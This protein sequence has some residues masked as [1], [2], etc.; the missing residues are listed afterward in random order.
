MMRLQFV[1]NYL[2]IFDNNDGRGREETG[3]IEL[4]DDDE[5][6]AFGEQVI[7]EMMQGSSRQYRGCA[8]EVHEGG[9][10]VGRIPL[11]NYQKPFSPWLLGVAMWQRGSAAVRKIWTLLCSK[12]R[13]LDARSRSLTQGGDSEADRSRFSTRAHRI[14]EGSS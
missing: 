14:D 8:M 11:E 6:F 10:I 1:R 7:R 9:R 13:D 4:F 5:A 12:W 3:Q 2:F